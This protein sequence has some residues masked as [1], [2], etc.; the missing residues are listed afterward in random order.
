MRV[1]SDWILHQIDVRGWAHRLGNENGDNFVY[2]GRGE[3]ILKLLIPP[4]DVPQDL[5]NEYWNWVEDSVLA[6]I[7]ELYPDLYSWIVEWQKRKIAELV[8]M[9]LTEQEEGQGEE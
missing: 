8:E 2:M 5:K 3:Y 6:P 4:L 9:N 1:R 7:K